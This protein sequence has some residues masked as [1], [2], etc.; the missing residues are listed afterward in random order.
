MN[1]MEELRKKLLD[2]EIV[3]NNAFNERLPHYIAE[4]L[5]NLCDTVNSLYQNTHIQ[6]MENIEE[7]KS[8]IATLTLTNKI[9]KSLLNLLVIDIPSKM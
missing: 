9:I 7:K 5:Y 2:F 1:M 8:L 4:Y 3:I 6:S